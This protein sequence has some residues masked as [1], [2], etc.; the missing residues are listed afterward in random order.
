MEFV[1]NVLSVGDGGKQPIEV[2]LIDALGIKSDDSEEFTGVG[3]KFSECRGGERELYGRRQTFV[4]ICPI[5]LRAV[6]VP[7]LGQ[8]F[9]TP[10]IVRCGGCEWCYRQGVEVQTLDKVVD[11]VRPPTIVVDAV[12]DIACSLSPQQRGD[13]RTLGMWRN[14]GDAG[15][16]AKADVVEATQLLH[17]GVYL[18]RVRSLW[19]DKLIR[20]YRGRVSSLSMPRTIGGESNLQ[21][22]YQ[23]VP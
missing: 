21:G 22:Y 16:D 9:V 6:R 7:F 15:G 11:D 13:C 2:A 18:S 17:N 1:K 14:G 5:Y 10:H 19:I 20:R 8:L 12:E 23:T 4:V 3:A